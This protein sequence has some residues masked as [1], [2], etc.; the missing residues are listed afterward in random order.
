VINQL[1]PAFVSFAVPARL[2]PQLR[3]AGGA[4]RLPVEAAPAGATDARSTGTVTFID[5]AID[6]GTDSIRVK[7]TFPNGDRRLWPGAFV[8]V[9]LQLAIDSEAIVA[10]S[11]AVQASQQGTFVFVVKSD[12]SVEA[13]AIKVDWIESGETIVADGLKAGEIVVTDGQLK[14]TP[15][16]KVTIKDAAVGKKGE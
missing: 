11:A 15:G 3:T 10:P 8:D 14:L 12:Q 7:A 1:T 16:T 2:L 9:T 6:Q 5:N 4:R 13:R